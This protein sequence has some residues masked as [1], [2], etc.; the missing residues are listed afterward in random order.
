MKVQSLKSCQKHTDILRCT[1]ELHYTQVW[2]DSYTVNLHTDT[3]F[4]FLSVIFSL[5][6]VKAGL[7]AARVHGEVPQR[8]LAEFLQAFVHLC[9]LRGR[10]AIKESSTGLYRISQRVRVEHSHD[11][12]KI[13]WVL[14][15]HQFEY[16]CLQ[17]LYLKLLRSLPA[18][19][20]NFIVLSL[21]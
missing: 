13:W 15:I 2:I 11:V 19:L 6:V 20:T 1:S 14:F 10:T 3:N 8:A 7:G 16:E 12:K 9:R 18:N 5:K 21:V 4:L 17:N